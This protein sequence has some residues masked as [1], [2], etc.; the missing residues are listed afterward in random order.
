MT[1]RELYQ[2]FQQRFPLEKLQYMPLDE[3]TNL[4]RDD[5]FC[6]WIDALFRK[7]STYSSNRK[8]REIDIQEDDEIEEDNRSEWYFVDSVPFNLSSKYFLSYDCRVVLAE[9]GYYL[10]VSDEYVK[11]GNYAEGFSSD[12]GNVWI[13]KPVDERGLR[14]VHN[15]G[16]D[17]YL[18]GY[19]RE[20]EKKI[21][22]TNPDDE[23]F[24]ITFNED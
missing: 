23:I 22:F 17:M 5:S 14:M 21:V 6:Y 2:A 11:L 12:D 19:I 13:K 3:Y 16:N 8:V 7:L 20:E 1:R 24:T 10:E 18:I 9:S 4:N 15:I